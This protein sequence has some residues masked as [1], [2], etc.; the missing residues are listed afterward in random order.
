MR[1]ATDASA[2]GLERRGH[3]RYRED[4]LVYICDG[5][6][7]RRGVL[8]DVSESG[9]RVRVDGGPLP[10]RIVLVDPR[11]GRSDLAAVI[12]CG[13]AEIGV[14]FLSEG[15]RYRVLRSPSDLAAG[16]EALPHLRASQV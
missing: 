7:A 13:E 12:W 15:I 10:G 6:L 3:P 16:M 9:A 8:M 1:C 14:R 5:A 11:T 2:E 4:S